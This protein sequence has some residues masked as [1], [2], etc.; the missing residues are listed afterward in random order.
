[1]TFSAPPFAW[2]DACTGEL[3]GAN[4]VVLTQAA[5]KIDRQVR[6][7]PPLKAGPDTLTTLLNQLKEGEVH[8]LKSVSNRI[9][10]DQLAFGKVPTVIVR[11]SI[12][13]LKK[14]GLRPRKLS[15]LKGYKGVYA[16]SFDAMGYRFEALNIEM[17]SKTDTDSTYEALLSGEAEFIV[18]PFYTS[19]I[20]ISERGLTK[21]LNNLPTSELDEF[22]YMATLK[23]S[24]Y[25]GYLPLF[26]KEIDLMRKSR[27]IQRLNTQYL[28]TWMDKKSCQ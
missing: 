17:T 7:A 24:E 3:T 18:T 19:I 6:F 2:N 22:L 5:K 25:E 23:G 15:E 1:M 27:Y 14:S 21:E 4:R 9:A 11:K 10:S 13:T 8:F 20:D 12:V 28:Q 16:D 26:D